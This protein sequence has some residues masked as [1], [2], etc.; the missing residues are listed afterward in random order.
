MAGIR[1]DEIARERADAE[2]YRW[3]R[4]YKAPQIAALLRL[5]EWAEDGSDH[6]AALDKLLTRKGQ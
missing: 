2:R 1:K 4:K 5:T 6:D 3:L